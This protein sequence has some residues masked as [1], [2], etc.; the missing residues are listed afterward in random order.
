LFFV[1]L[2][3]CGIMLRLIT[4]SGFKIE[5]VPVPQAPAP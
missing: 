1:G 5:K 4:L 2:L 3:G